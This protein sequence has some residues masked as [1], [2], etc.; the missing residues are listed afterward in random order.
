[1]SAVLVH[2]NYFEQGQSLA[3]ACKM[4]RE[5]GADGLEFRR[6]PSGY[7][8]SDLEYLDEVSSALDQY[9]L[10]WISFGAPGV[11]LMS[12]D[13]ARKERELDAAEK[14]Y[15]KAA[16]RFPLR[17]VN[18]FAGDLRNP[19]PTLPGHEYVRHGSA[20]ATDAQ[21][22]SAVMGFRRLSAIAEELGFR[23]AFETHGVYL[24]DSLEATLRLV[25][26][27]GSSHVGVLW[28]HANLMLF[29]KAPEFNEVVQ[30]TGKSLFY[31]HLKNL[32]VHPSRFLAAGSLSGGILN[33]RDQLTQ[34]NRAGYAGPLCIESPRAGDREEFLREDLAYLRRLLKDLPNT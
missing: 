13:E 29:S 21:W 15:R 7:S 17:I 16:G 27:I 30:A 28:D 26:E 3:R 12:A 20:I 22:E 19:D 5:L 8:K 18:T 34:L 32:L 31:V 9:P 14:F 2:I 25:Q 6:K 24:H 11:D 23:F 10:D 4:T 1:M 33:I